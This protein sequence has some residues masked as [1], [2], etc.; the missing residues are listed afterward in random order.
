[1]Y[2]WA[3][4]TPN[5]SYVPPT[6]ANSLVLT[7]IT[8]KWKCLLILSL[9][10]QASIGIPMARGAAPYRLLCSFLSGVTALINYIP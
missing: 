7:Q 5:L 8:S 10:E 3:L 4:Q 1:M 9:P 6:F 2:A